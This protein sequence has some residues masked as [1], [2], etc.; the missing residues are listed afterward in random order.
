MGSPSPTTLRMWGLQSLGV[1]LLAPSGLQSMRGPSPDPKGHHCHLL[2]SLL[3]LRWRQAVLG[4]RLWSRRL[5][6]LGVTMQV[7][8]LQAGRGRALLLPILAPRGPA[9]DEGDLTEGYFSAWFKSLP[10]PKPPFPVC[11]MG[12]VKPTE[13]QGILTPQPFG[14]SRRKGLRAGASAWGP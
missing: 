12:T 5:L 3:S 1:G 13:H 7:Q 4:G 10:V 2:I 11:N 14:G 8:L 6:G 9:E